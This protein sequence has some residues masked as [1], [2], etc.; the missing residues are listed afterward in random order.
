[1]TKKFTRRTLVKIVHHLVIIALLVL[2][3]LPFYILIINSFKRPKDITADPFSFPGFGNTPLVY[4]AYGVAW[5]DIKNYI[6]NTVIVAFLEIFGVLLFASLAAY[7][8]TRFKFKGKDTLFTVFLAFMMIPSILTLAT[9]F[10]LVSIKLNLG[11][12]FAG[13]VLPAIAGGM[14][15]NI[16][17]IRTFFSGVPDSLFEA[18]ELDGASHVRR[19]FSIALP[20]CMPILFTI[21]L[22][23]LLG[24]WN[25]VIWADLILHRTENLHTISVGVFNKYGGASKTITDTVIYAGYCIASLPLII[26]FAFTSKQFIKGLTNG[27]IKM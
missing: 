8:F 25:D 5:N 6:L 26:A 3:L 27:A 1:M 23:T 13:V 2:V 4:T 20:L 12:S 17:L 9:Q 21:G 19:W 15:V 10:S 18:A 22:S 7:G 11:G 24:A 16:F 14:P